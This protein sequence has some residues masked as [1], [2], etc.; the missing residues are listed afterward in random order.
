[1]IFQSTYKLLKNDFYG[2]V[3]N[4]LNNILS[5]DYAITF[6]PLTAEHADRGSLSPIKDKINILLGF[7]D[8]YDS[9]YHRNLLSK[10]H[11]VFNQY[12]SADEESKFANLFSLP[13]G[14]NPNIIEDSEHIQPI[15]PSHNRS[16]DVFFTGH[17][18]SKQRYESM[19]NN[20]SYILND[21]R[22]KLYKLDF[23]ITSG[24]MRGFKGPEYYKRL[25]NSKIVFCPPGNISNETYRLYEAMMC[26]CVV[27]C[28]ILPKTQI[29]KNI[30]V[31]EVEDFNNKGAKV[32]FDLLE[33][34]SKISDIQ[35]K[36]IN[37]WNN[38]FS[39][40][41]VAKYILSKIQ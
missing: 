14:Y 8:E 11:F 35:T 25:Y 27:I 19:I 36:I 17:M 16:I 10:Y 30:P 24:F 1:M 22:R 32:M 6:D 34:P 13:L 15:T 20:I 7:W 21:S 41:Q 3:Y 12:I 39:V 31:I 9:K 28:P 4:Y 29:Y 26:G 38:N 40:E 5:D 2:N 23:N 37:Y 33:D 18:S